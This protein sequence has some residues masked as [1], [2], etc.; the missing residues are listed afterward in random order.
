MTLLFSVV[1]LLFTSIRQCCYPAQAMNGTQK[2][3]PVKETGALRTAKRRKEP[4]GQIAEKNTRELQHLPTILA[5]NG[6]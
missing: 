4:H 5:A 3:A 2:R 6:K 1:F